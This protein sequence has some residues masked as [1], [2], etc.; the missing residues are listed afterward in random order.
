[1]WQ[2][3]GDKRPPFATT[4]G[5]DQESVWDYPRPPALAPCELLVEVKHGTSLLASTQGALR[6]LETASPPTFYLPPDCIDWARL[7]AVSGSSFCEWKGTA[8][9]W[10]L[11]GSQQPVA[12][13]Y[14]HPSKPFADIAGYLSFFPARVG[15]FVAGERVQPQPGP[16]YGGWITRSVT[17]PF[18]GEPGTGHW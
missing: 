12:W 4:P 9:Y 13:G 16:F 8:R 3:T 18:K 14:D 7:S 6:V 2:Y 11:R 15:C 1:M 10:S 17:G 5:P